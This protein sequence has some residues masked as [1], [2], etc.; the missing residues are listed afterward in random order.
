MENACVVTGY[1]F[2]HKNHN[3][4]RSDHQ[5]LIKYIHYVHPACESQ[6]YKVKTPRTLIWTARP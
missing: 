4:M 5:S 3:F 1:D 6:I 2:V